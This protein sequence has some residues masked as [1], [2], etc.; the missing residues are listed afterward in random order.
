MLWVLCVKGINDKE[1]DTVQHLVVLLVLYIVRSVNC[2]SRKSEIMY[3]CKCVCAC[4]YKYKYTHFCF[5]YIT[6]SETSSLSSESTI[7]LT[8]LIE[9]SHCPFPVLS[10]YYCKIFLEVYLQCCM[11]ITVFSISC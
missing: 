9:V 3:V 5:T 8:R 10:L 4:I 1:L 2:T 7:R 6:F 11:T